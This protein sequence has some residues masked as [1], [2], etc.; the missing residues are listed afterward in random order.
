MNSLDL[1]GRPEDTRVV[2]AMSGGVDSSVVAAI[3]KR[4]NYDTDKL[5]LAAAG[6]VPDDCAVLIIAGP[7]APLL[8]PEKQAIADYLNGGGHVLVL[9][10]PRQDVGLSDLLDQ[11]Y[12]TVGNDIV[13]DPGS[14]YQGDALTP[15]PQPQVGH[16]ISTSLSVMLMPGTRSM[17]VKP[18][19]G[20]DFAIR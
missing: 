4:E 19:A 6:K 8:D 16:R 17:S 12:V 13:V 20:S 3:L 10:D 9:L 1:P 5:T 11:W 7:R 15:I 18:S 14:N 2:V